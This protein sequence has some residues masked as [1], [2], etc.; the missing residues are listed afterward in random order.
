[1]V[2][3]FEWKWKDIAVECTQFLGPKG[4]AAVQVSPPNEHAILA[5]HPWYQR[6]QP[7]SYKLGSRSG[8]RAEFIDM[9]RIC[10]A[11]GVD[12]YV[13]AIINHM[14]G[15]LQPGE[16]R[17]GSAGAE[18]SR[19]SYLDYSYDDFHHCG[20]NGDGAIHNYSDRWEVQNCQLGNLTDLDTE[21]P[22]VQDKISGYLSELVDLGVSGFRIDAA[23]HIPAESIEK[24]LSKVRGYPY[25]YQEVIDQGGEPIKA[26]EYFRN[27]G[28]TEFRY[29][30]DIGRIF[31]GGQLS[32][33]NGAHLF[34]PGW[35][36]HADR[37]SNRLR[38]QP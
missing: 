9:V 24:I 18:Y 28:V 2:H 17:I 7:V 10:K 3:L 32:W 36:L 1:M 26:S 30:L 4:F 23:K 11:A 33:L 37:Q 13:D 25:L 27:G 15:L 38:R 5:N 31:S 35:G 20:P 19:F 16:T 14:T 29:S 34:G 22:S 6:Y 12:I 21:S 8:S